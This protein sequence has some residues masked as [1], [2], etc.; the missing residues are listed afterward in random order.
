MSEWQP[1]ETAPDGP[2]LVFYRFPHWDVPHEGMA[3]CWRV[4]RDWTGGP[5]TIIDFTPTAWMALPDPPVLP[6]PQKTV[7]APRETI[8]QSV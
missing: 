5:A 6:L 8:H 1:I 4:G 2:I 7:D 3:V